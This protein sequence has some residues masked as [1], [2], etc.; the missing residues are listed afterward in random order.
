ME[1]NS[2]AP[3]QSLLRTIFRTE[4]AIL[5]VGIGCIGYGLATGLNVM[6]IFFGLCIVGGSVMLHFVR[7]KDWEAHWSDM[8]RIRQEHE[9]RMAEESEKKKKQ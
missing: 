8:D 1:A 4:T 7:K 9:L 3:E 2:K 5:L 6:P